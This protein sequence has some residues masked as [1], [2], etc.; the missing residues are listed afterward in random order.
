M[1]GVGFVL[2]GM[3]GG[4]V[5]LNWMIPWVKVGIEIIVPVLITLPVPASM[6][7][8]VPFVAELPMIKGLAIPPP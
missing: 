4:G 1:A 8:A 3:V 6:L 5:V 7:P 2:I